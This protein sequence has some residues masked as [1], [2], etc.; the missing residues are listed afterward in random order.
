MSLAKFCVTE[1]KSSIT[2]E[3]SDTALLGNSTCFD[4]S[5]YKY[6][7]SVYITKL[8]VYL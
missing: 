4:Q 3:L 5:Q 1:L 6:F 8:I 7:L 2:T